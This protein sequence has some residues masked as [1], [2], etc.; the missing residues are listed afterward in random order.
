VYMS[1]LPLIFAKYCMN[2]MSLKAT[3]TTRCFISYNHYNHLTQNTELVHI[4]RSLKNAPF[5]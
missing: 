4:E 1:P 3:G 5:K 2:K